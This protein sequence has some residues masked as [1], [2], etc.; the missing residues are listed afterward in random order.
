MNI[1]SKLKAVAELSA[2]AVMLAVAVTAQ[3]QG[4]TTP[5]SMYG[6]GILGDR[7]TSMQRQMGS[8]G[9]AMNSGRQVNVMNPAS[10]AATDSLTFLFD[11]GADLTMLWSQENS[12][13]GFN[14]GGGV[15][16]V[17]MQFP[18]SKHFGGSIGLLPYSSVGYS[19]GNDIMHGTMENQ[20]TGGIN[21]LYLG[22]AGSVAGFSLGFNI[23]YNF[24]NIINDV[25]ST[26]SGSGRSKFEH[27]MEVRDWNILIG[28]QYKLKIDRFNSMVLGLTYSPKKA[29]LGT[30]RA[31]TQEMSQDAQPDTVATM[32]LKNNYYTP[33]MVGAGISYTYSKSSKFT[34]E[35]DFLWQGWSDCK[36]SPMYA[37]KTG[38]VVFDGMTFND[39]TRY[40]VGAEFVPKLRGGYLQKIA[41]RIGGYYS[42]DYLRIGNSNVKEYGVTC[43]FGFPTP[44]GR[45]VIN[46][47]L[48]WKHRYATPVKLIGENYFNIT[49][50]VNFNEVWFFKRKIR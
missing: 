30:S 39:R 27:V 48:E 17:T 28:A 38:K 4:T 25:Y 34:V 49:L 44:E 40:A 42:N 35:A 14:V 11:L 12:A 50:G 46:L 18:I 15:D 20:G 47:G 13:K 2:A 22:L 7:A 33:N 37:D 19:F 32:K 26:P 1:I 36:Y 16:Y 24:G 31:T 6:Y 23:S 29:L 45:T 9:V 43:G 41:Y 10:Y 8:V 5:Y 21:E 3:A